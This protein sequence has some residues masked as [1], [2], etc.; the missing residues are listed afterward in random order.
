M[1]HVAMGPPSRWHG[2]VLAGGAA[3]RFGRD[4]VFERVSGVRLIDAACASL[5]DAEGVSVLVGSPERLARVAPRLP[6]GVTAIA[7]ELPGRGPIGGVATALDCARERAVQASGSAWVAV[8]A[9]DLPLVP[10]E[11]WGWL[12][13]QY[14]PGVPAV[15]ARD[16][17]GRWEPLAALYHA[18]LAPELTALVA[19]E[20]GRGLAFH[21]WLDAL[22]RAGRVVAVDPSPM[23]AEALLNVNRPADALRLEQ[24]LN[25]RAGGPDG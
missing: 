12:A 5:A 7:D 14:R 22:E 17:S 1:P 15:V 11:W 21:G 4:K 6:S 10:R 24:L 8:L 25:D 9:A 2:A 3:R 23:P 16:S 13:G 19:V 20:E 18:Q